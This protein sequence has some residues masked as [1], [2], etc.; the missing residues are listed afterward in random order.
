MDQTYYQTYLMLEERNWWFRARKGIL[1]S[2]LESRVFCGRKPLQI[3][4]VGCGP[5]ALYVRALQEAGHDIAGID[6]SDQSIGMA[7]KK[8]AKK[9]YNMSMESFFAYEKEP[10]DIILMLDMLE[11]VQNDLELVQSAFENIREAG[12]LFITVPAYQCL[13]GPHDE[14]NHHFRRYTKRKLVAIVSGA[15][16]Q[17]EKASYFNT[18]LF[19]LALVKKFAD[20]FQGGGKKDFN[21]RSSGV[22]NRVFTW[23]FEVEKYFLSWMSF[24]YGLS[25]LVIAHKAKAQPKNG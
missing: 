10:R 24:P 13:W 19:P 21:D 2:L 8:G 7:R 6:F 15:G 5:S 12:T 17:V 23:I 14:V 11:H 22:I 20:K 4:D 1:L 3:L 25:I 9:V 16:F 18:L